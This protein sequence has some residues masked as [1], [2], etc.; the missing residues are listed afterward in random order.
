MWENFT[1]LLIREN[2]DI[3]ERPE[4]E[5]LEA[6][7]R[8]AVNKVAIS[9]RRTCLLSMKQQHGE[10]FRE[11]Y[12]NVRASADACNFKIKCHHACCT[13]LADIDYTSLV[14]KDVIIT[15]IQDTDQ[16]RCP[17]M[18]RTWQERRQR[19]CHLR[20]I[21]GDCPSCFFWF[22]SRYWHQCWYFNKQACSETRWSAGQ[23]SLNKAEAGIERKL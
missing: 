17:C 19:C 22:K 14:V 6:I 3:L 15:G 21:Q 2:P 10:T 12:A 4:S 23:R 5:A 11:Y 9:V 8:F 1:K 7:K 13:N 16:K 18:G 20:R